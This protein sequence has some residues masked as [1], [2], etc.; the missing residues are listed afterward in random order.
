MTDPDLFR[1]TGGPDQTEDPIWVVDALRSGDATFASDGTAHVRLHI[2]STGQTAK[3]GDC[4]AHRDGTIRVIPADVGPN[5]CRHCGDDE[6][7][8]G[9]QWH[10]EV[11]FHRWIAPTQEQIKDRMFARRIG[12]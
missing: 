3:P 12:R 5:A 2:A 9:R 1:W 7:H 8:H 11:G 10:R 6:Y 4:L